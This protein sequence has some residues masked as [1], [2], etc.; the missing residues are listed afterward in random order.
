MEKKNRI[1]LLF[2][3]F[4]IGISFLITL[5]PVTTLSKK[6]AISLSRFPLKLVSLSISPIH[7]IIN[8]NRSLSQNHLLEQENQQLKIRLMQLQ[9]AGSQN[10][11]LQKLLSFR[12][13][14]E[15][16]LV[17]A[18]VIAFDAS[19]LR[20][21]LI[22]DRGR[23]SDVKVG[24]P[25]IVP[26]GVVGIVAEVGRTVSRIILINDLDFSMAAKIKPSEAIGVI[27][28][29]LEGACRLKY[30][31]LDED[32]EIGDEVVSS[33]KNS[34]FPAGI[35]VGTVTDISRERSGFTLF[36]VVKP[37]VKLSSLEEV[38]IITNR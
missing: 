21:S 4:L 8:C 15:F 2:F 1:I 11:R 22:V 12:E 17:A 10:Q 29:S 13:R 37:K 27:S 26:E 25:V 18:R 23:G 34:R 33:G 3:I 36:T 5:S 38:L 9:E 7:G 19:N 20:R 16:S 31:D 6:I 30:L 24:N 35:P 14:S 32:V 28:G